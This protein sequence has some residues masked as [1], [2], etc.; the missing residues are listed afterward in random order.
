MSC[1]C[2][3]VLTH[4]NNKYCNYNSLKKK[5]SLNI[6]NRGNFLPQ[7]I[8]TCNIEMQWLLYYRYIADLFLYFSKLI[9]LFVVQFASGFKNSFYI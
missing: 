2:K 8:T 7:N 1:D 9:M 3:V 4:V 6:W 5:V